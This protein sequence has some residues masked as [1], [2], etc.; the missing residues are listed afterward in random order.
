MGRPVE[1]WRVYLTDDDPPTPATYCPACAEFESTDP[2]RAPPGE[3]PAH[4]AARLQLELRLGL[5]VWSTD[6]VG[7]DLLRRRKDDP[8]IRRWSLR[9]ERREAMLGLLRII[10][11]GSGREL[12]SVVK[13]VALWKPLLPRNQVNYTEVSNGLF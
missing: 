11:R 8:C 4:R 1:R 13:E 9:S 6:C 2:S 12:D 3:N 5:A 7:F 10:N